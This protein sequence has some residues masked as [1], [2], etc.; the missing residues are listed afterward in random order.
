MV[1][2]SGD[3]A[4]RLPVPGRPTTFAYG[5][6]RACWACSRCRTGGLCLLFCFAFLFFIYLFFIFVVVV[7]VVWCCCLVLLFSS[8]L[9]YIPFLLPHLFGD[10]WRY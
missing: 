7:V 9:S 5:R 3:G 8:R 4:G 2:G 6:A 10:G 1:V